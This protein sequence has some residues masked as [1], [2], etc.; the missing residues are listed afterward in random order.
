M[1]KIEDNQFTTDLMNY[2]KKQNE[3]FEGKKKK[4]SI[5]NNTTLKAVA[6]TASLNITY[7]K[8]RK[9]KKKM[10]KKY[11]NS[12]DE[13]ENDYNNVDGTVECSKENENFDDDCEDDDGDGYNVNYKKSKPNKIRKQN[14][15]LAIT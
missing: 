13:N 4:E 5:K 3:F 1:K 14:K 11:N 15:D 7:Q 9:P 10:I 6:K 12:Y 2:N 8:K